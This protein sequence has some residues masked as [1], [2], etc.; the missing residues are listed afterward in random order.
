MKKLF[1]GIAVVSGLMFAGCN[2]SFLEKTP[3][4]DLTENNAFNS[5]D[6]FKNFMWPCYEMFVNTT[7]RTS[8]RNNG[9]GTGGQYDGDVDAGYLNKRSPSGFNQFAYQT[10]GSTASGNGWDFSS[11][12]R[13]VNIMLSHL[14]ESDM[15]ETEKEHWQSV[16]YFFHSFWYMELIDRFGD[17]PWVNKVLTEASPEI[18]GTRMPRVEV[19]DS[20]LA[21]LQWAETHIG[22][23]KSQDGSNTINRDCVRAAL[24]RFT[25]REGT[26]R[27]Y[28]GLEGSDKYLQECVRVSELLMADYP[29]LYTGTDGQPGAGYGEMWTTEDLGT[30]PGVI[31]YKSYVQDINPVQGGC[32]VEH[33]SSHD[34]EMNQNTVDLYLMKNGK[35]IHNTTSGYHGDKSMYTT[36]R[37]RDPRLYHTVMPP[38]KVEANG[39]NKPAENP[40][41]SWGYTS[42]PA[43]REY[44]DLMGANYTCSNPGVGMKRLPAQNWS[45]SLVPQIPNLGTGAFVTCRSGYYLWKLYCGWEENF[46]NGTL[47]VA[48]KPIFKIEEVLLNYAEAKAELGGFTQ[49]VADKSINKLRDRAGVARMTVSEINDNFDPDRPFYYPEGNT[50][51]TQVPALLWEVRRERIIELMGEGFGFYDVRRWRMAPWFL[52]RAAKGIWVTKEYALS[53]SMTLYNPNTGVSDGQAGSMT[54]GYLYLF[55]DPIAEGKGW[56]DKYYLYQVPTDEILLNPNLTQNPGW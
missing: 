39:A 8:T 23:F 49:D 40:N 11:Y 25:L 32:Y 37:D 4:T 52:N 10:K 18:Y 5:Y 13:R 42:D 20:V 16:G 33:T 35:P 48:D 21:R 22:D 50:A 9:W 12:I 54:E 47:N 36:F 34:V 19:A 46:N 3:V 56:L 24:S 53:K 27:K 31:L 38:Y 28:H 55:N 41:A 7:I 1:I 45:A 26:W 15:T 43:D 44:I 14:E 2:D 6:N 29:T 51:G 30:V 17:V